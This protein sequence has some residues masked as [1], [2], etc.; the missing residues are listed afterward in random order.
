M[1]THTTGKEGWKYLQ[2][3]V[4]QKMIETVVPTLQ[5]SRLE[6]QLL[7]WYYTRESE[8][9]Q[10]CRNKTLRESYCPTETTLFTTQSYFSLPQ[11]SIF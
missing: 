7:H 1:Q 6:T 10:S 9:E 5:A 11:R 3:P 2:H 4:T 8:R